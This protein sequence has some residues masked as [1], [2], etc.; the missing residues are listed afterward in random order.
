[1]G[2]VACITPYNFDRQHGG[3]LGSTSRWAAV[4]VRPKSQNPLTVSTSSASCTG[5]LPRKASSVV[6]GSTPDTGEALVETRDID[7]VSFTGSTSVG[8]RIGEVGGR[9]MKRMLLE[10]GGKGAALVF[11]DAN[12]KTAVQMIGS[13]WT[14]HS[15]QICTAPTRAIVQR[16]IYDQVVE[17]LAKMA[18]VLKVGDPYEPGTVLGPVITA[19]HRD[20]VERYIRRPEEGGEIVAGGERPEKPDRGYYVRRRSSRT[21]ARA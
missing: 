16:P 20:R 11:D 10:L 2:A 5:R 19:P 8:Q 7:M 1:M 14:F 9:T 3:Q 17:G 12:V 6:T 15:G 13:V 4:V 21:A 18:T